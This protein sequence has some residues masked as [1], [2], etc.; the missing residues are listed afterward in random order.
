MCGCWSRAATS[1]S[2]RKRS[3][4][5]EAASS[6]RSTLSAT[7][8]SVLEVLGEV[9]G[10][11]AALPELA[12]DAVAVGESFGE[13]VRDVGHGPRNLPGRCLV[14]SGER[15]A[16]LLEVQREQAVPHG[17]RGLGTERAVHQAQMG[18]QGKDGFGRRRCRRE[19]EGR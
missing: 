16:L 17:Q 15:P 9:D 3:G 4:P 6:G 19:V 1:I 7:L 2:R 5:S 18:E 12:L 10:R 8:R 14:A 11:H 13:P